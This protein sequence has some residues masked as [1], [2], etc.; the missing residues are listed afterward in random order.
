[1]SFG[2]KGRMK[3]DVSAAGSAPFLRLTIKFKTSSDGPL[4]Q[5]LSFSKPGLRIAF[6][7]L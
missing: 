7:R 6:V 1:V 2:V 4:G 3:H 5:L